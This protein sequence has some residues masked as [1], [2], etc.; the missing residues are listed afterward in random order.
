MVFDLLD[1]KIGWQARV[2]GGQGFMV[3][4]ILVQ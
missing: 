3:T 2:D 1:F 4:E